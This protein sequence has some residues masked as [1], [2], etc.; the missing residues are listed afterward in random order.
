M[1]VQMIEDAMLQVELECR[2]NARRGAADLWAEAR[3][4]W[5]TGRDK[6]ALFR[7]LKTASSVDFL[8]LLDD[9]PL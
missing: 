3:R 6:L 4:S 7:A 5:V 2:R 9:M 8:R 1:N